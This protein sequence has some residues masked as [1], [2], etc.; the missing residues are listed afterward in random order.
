MAQDVTY[1]AM[2]APITI[3]AIFSKSLMGRLNTV[4]HIAAPKDIEK[5]DI[6]ILVSISRPH[7]R[8]NND[9]DRRQIPQLARI[10]VFIYNN[11]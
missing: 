4:I 10:F 6:K 8:A 9:K 1:I 2:N 7:T 11:C 5:V 3:E